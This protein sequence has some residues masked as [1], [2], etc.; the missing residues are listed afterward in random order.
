LG[1]M[2][3]D[4][5]CTSFTG[6]VVTEW[7]SVFKR[8]I[9]GKPGETQKVGKTRTLKPEEITKVELKIQDTTVEAIPAFDGSRY[10]ATWSRPKGMRSVNAHVQVTYKAYHSFLETPPLKVSL[11][12]T[13]GASQLCVV[14]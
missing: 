13:T 14:Q 1:G 8:P 11:R 10:I 5:Y 4:W 2:D 7:Y 3:C 9:Q 6:F 12:D